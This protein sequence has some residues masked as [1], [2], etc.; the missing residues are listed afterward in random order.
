MVGAL[1]KA[2]AEI[3]SLQGQVAELREQINSASIGG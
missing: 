1:K 2:I 3:E